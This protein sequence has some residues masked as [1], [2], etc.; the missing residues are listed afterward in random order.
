MLDA[1]W[2]IEVDE[3]VRHERLIARHETFG[4]SPEAARAWSLGPD[5]ANARLVAATRARADRVIR[6]S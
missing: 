6:A 1:C 5:E 3:D 2:F 4:K